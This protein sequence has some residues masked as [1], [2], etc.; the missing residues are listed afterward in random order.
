MPDE[1][2]EEPAL[3]PEGDA[4]RTG[5]SACGQSD[6]ERLTEEGAGEGEGGRREAIVRADREQHL[7]LQLLD[8]LQE[9]LAARGGREERVA[10]HRNR[11][12]EAERAREV[13]D[14][15]ASAIQKVLSV[16]RRTHEDDLAHRERPLPGEGSVAGA[17][18]SP[19]RGL[20]RND[21]GCVD[22]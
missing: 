16:G 13:D 6:V 11:R 19:A 15:T 2:R 12:I 20:C 7:T 10:R 8:L 1:K 18:M 14:M 4:R 3:E 17:L 22:D 5:W 9:L 21:A